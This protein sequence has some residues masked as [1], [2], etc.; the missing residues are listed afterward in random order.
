M[1]K[2]IVIC[3]DGTWNTPDQM[4][5]GRMV[6]SNVVKICRA[7]DDRD[8]NGVEQRYYYDAGVGTGGRLDKL[9]GGIF[10]IGVS[11]N[12]LQAYKWLATV[13]QDGDL[14]FLFGFSRG[15]YTARSIGG[16][17][18]RCGILNDVAEKLEATANEAFKIYRMKKG[19]K[20]DAASQ[21]FREAH[22]YPSNE[23][24]FIG[25]WDTVGALGVPIKGLNRI[26]RSR[27]KFHDV[28]LGSN[29]KNAYHAVAI[30]ERRRAFEPTLW[31]VE[32]EL[33]DQTVV[34]AWFPG[35]HSNVGGGYADTGLS[36]RALDWM[37]GRAAANGLKFQDDYLERRIDPNYHGELRKSMKWYYGVPRGGLDRV[38]GNEKAAGEVIH[39]SAEERALHPTNNYQSPNLIGALE[40]K[41]VP[42]TK[43]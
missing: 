35:V 33:P 3:T 38:I 20:K 36:D 5:R 21:A 31:Q 41:T 24:K 25:V 9:K 18:G 42:V 23:I 7:L 13:Y 29:V 19:D 11:E 17:V 2:N 8:K 37:I 28:T 27:H 39:F 12:I 30:D 15:A 14:I 10:G 6:P 1:G 34:Q 22:S 43:P 32:S 4:D 26:G 40:K 16:L